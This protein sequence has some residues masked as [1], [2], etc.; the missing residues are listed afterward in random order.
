MT[1]TWQDGGAVQATTAVTSV[2]FTFAKPVAAGDLLVALMGH[3]SGAAGISDSSGNDWVIAGNT[4]LY[5]SLAYCLSAS[6]TASLTL[7][8]TDTTAGTMQLI[9]DRFTPSGPVIFGGYSG[10]PAPDSFKGNC[11]LLAGVPGGQLVYGGL[12]TGSANVTCMAGSSNG[13]VAASSTAV[14][15]GSGSGFSEYV[16]RTA[17]GPQSLTWAASAYIGGSGDAAQQAWFSCTGPTSREIVR[18]GIA[19]F[20]GGSTYDTDARAYRGS[21]PLLANGLSTVRAYQPKRMDDV[22]YVKGQVAGRGMGAAMV[23]E[24]SADAEHRDAKPAGTGRKHVI[25]TVNLYGFHMA[26]Q[27]Y[28]EDAAADVD[29]LIE[30][31]KSQLRDDITLGGICYQA[32][33]SRAGI[34]TRIYPSSEYEET[35]ATAFTIT[36]EAEVEIVA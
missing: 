2:S 25:Y 26:Y 36:F 6:A 35:T 16:T 11:G 27:P 23:V 8:A 31:I 32:G 21:G 29:L 10:A 1:F 14:A 18:T 22:D 7:T 30:A 15:N 3:N 9:A 4:G 5:N 12:H 33:E 17:G 28:A 20:F 19:Q 13:V 34:K 24:M